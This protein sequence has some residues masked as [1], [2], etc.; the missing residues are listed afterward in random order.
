MPK[1]L[2]IRNLN[3][4]NLSIAKRSFSN[5]Y[6]QAN[7]IS[8]L[9]KQNQTFLAVRD[10][11]ELSSTILQS[12]NIPLILNFSE[13][14]N[15]TSNKI[16]GALTRII[17]LET[18]KNVN[19]VDVEMEWDDNKHLPEKFGVTS[20]PCLVAVRN[21]FPVDYYVPKDLSKTDVDWYGLKSWIEKNAD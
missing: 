2:L 14:N 1:L 4:S 5:W 20:L 3:I 21:K 13:R 17:L 9:K 7:A 15:T 10:E 12:G 16:T 18:E 11:N 8:N 6:L 19:A